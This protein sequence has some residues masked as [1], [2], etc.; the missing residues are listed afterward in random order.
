MKKLDE[1]DIVVQP[2]D[3][4]YVDQLNADFSKILLQ[5]K[6]ILAVATEGVNKNN[7]IDRSTQVEHR[8]GQGCPKSGLRA[9]C[10]PRWTFKWP[11]VRLKAFSS[12][13]ALKWHKPGIH[14]S[15]H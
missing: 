11:A 14:S 10:G 12:P 1:I 6:K 4:Y 2:L 3:A 7:R 13:E 15:I 8:I 5:T 9:K